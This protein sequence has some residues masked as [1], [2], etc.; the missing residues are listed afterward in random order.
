VERFAGECGLVE[1]GEPLGKDAVDGNDLPRHY[2]Q[3]VVGL[4]L[5][6]WHE[7]NVAADSLVRSVRCTF[8]QGTQIA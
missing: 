1:D 3:Q 8:E 2:H 7:N 4:D 5:V 6:E